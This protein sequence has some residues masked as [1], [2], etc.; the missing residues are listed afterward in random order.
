MPIR[1]RINQLLQENPHLSVRRVSLDAGLSDSM[2]HK[3][4]TGQTASMTVANLE[5]LA[6]A[7]GVSS[8]WLIFGDTPREDDP[9]LAL[10][11]G[12][13]PAAKRAQALKVLE[14]FADNDED[15]AA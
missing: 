15:Q 12:H 8:R 2:L 7:L 3:Y 11:W 4:L 1:A 13:I 6:S 9:E 5:K 14:A 10:I